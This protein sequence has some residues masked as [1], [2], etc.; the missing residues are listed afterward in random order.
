MLNY[1]SLSMPFKTLLVTA[2]FLSLCTGVCTSIL[3]GKKP[4]K[5]RQLLL[6]LGTAVLAAM[7]LL[8]TSIIP[9]ER[10]KPNI[11]SIAIGFA[12]LPILISVLLWLLILLYLVHVIAAEIKRRS[13]A[14]TLS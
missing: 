2:L 12:E 1:A 14:I 11:P 6:I 7:L 10:A 5:L 4:G 3:V 9:A 13:P 8:Y